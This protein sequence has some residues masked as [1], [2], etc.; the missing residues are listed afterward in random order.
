MLNYHILTND[1]DSVNLRRM[2]G[3]LFAIENGARAIYDADE[4]IRLSHL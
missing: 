1:S 2:V 4:T 3:Y